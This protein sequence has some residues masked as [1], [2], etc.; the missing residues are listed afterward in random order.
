MTAMTN[1]FPPSKYMSFV[2]ARQYLACGQTVAQHRTWL[3]Q[4]E[5]DLAP[6]K[7]QCQRELQAAADKEGSYPLAASD[8]DGSLATIVAALDQHRLYWTRSCE[9]LHD[10][11]IAADIARYE[12]QTL[13]RDAHQRIVDAW[14]A[15]EL[16]LYG[17][18]V[19]TGHRRF[20]LIRPAFAEMYSDDEWGEI[21]IRGDAMFKHPDGAPG[22]SK[23]PMYTNLVIERRALINWAGRSGT[24]TDVG[25]KKVSPSD[26]GM[27]PPSAEEASSSL[28][29]DAIHS[30]PQE[31]ADNESAAPVGK[32]RRKS[33]A[34]DVA[35]MLLDALYGAGNV[36]SRG[37]SGK[38]I[39]G[40]LADLLKAENKNR[41]TPLHMPH[42]RTINREIGH[43][44]KSAKPA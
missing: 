28:P 9:A 44:N 24:A 33:P 22:F 35:S 5:L 11:A 20:E 3:Y 43:R 29:N 27:V 42:M 1:S 32:K 7:E 14:L 31:K 10:G 2:D 19:W 26:E 18:D 39:E 38:Q 30:T 16:P 40:R 23:R 8:L 17:I 21:E 41:D 37:L 6:L 25:I 12:K 15:G 36:P 34:R 13:R 4:Q